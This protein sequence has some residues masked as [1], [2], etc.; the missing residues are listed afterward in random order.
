MLNLAVI[1]RE[2][3]AARPDA[4][5]LLHDGGTVTYAQLDARSDAVAAA[6]AGR[7]IGPGAAV[8]LQ[9]PNIPEFPV[10]Y[11]G[12]LK[13]GAIVVPLNVMLRAPEVPTSSPTPAPGR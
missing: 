4:P 8:A 7:G 2:S 9:L 5:A 6:L 10:V 11:Y 1:L 3:A 12:I 13:T